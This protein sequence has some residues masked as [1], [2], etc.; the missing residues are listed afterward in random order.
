P[1]ANLDAKL[2]DEMR[3]FIRSLQRRVGIT[4]LY[5]THDQ[6]EAMTVSDRVVVMFGGHIHQIGSPRD[7]Y[8]RPATRDVANFI[9]KSNLF[10]GRIV[11][12]QGMC[13]SVNTSVGLMRCEAPSWIELGAE[14]HVMV[15]PEAIRLASSGNGLLG[16]ITQQHFLGNLIDYGVT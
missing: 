7:I 2:R 8:F 16:R 11:G 6:A 3:V 10:A 14:A 5:V 1:L 13:V 15:R 12:R 4:T 9:G